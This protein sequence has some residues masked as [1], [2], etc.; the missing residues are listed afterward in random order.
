MTG[1][2]DSSSGHVYRLAA[3]LTG[4]QQEIEK[5]RPEASQRQLEPSAVAVTP[6]EDPHA[7]LER[8]LIAELLGD[9]GHTLRS[10]D[11]LPREQQRD[12]LRYAATYATL[13]LSDIEARARYVNEID[14]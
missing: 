11:E 10:L 4:I 14:V 9:R 5:R 7:A 13:R 12:V 1:I 3:G 8:A 6:V 2:A